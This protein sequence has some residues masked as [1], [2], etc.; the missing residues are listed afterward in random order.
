MNFY[1]LISKKTML[2]KNW[3]KYLGI[4]TVLIC[5]FI[6][7]L[8]FIVDPYNITDYNIL[9]IK[10]KFARDDRNMKVNQFK[11]LPRFDNILI[12][13]SRVYSINPDTVSKILGGTTY[14]F[15]VGTATIEDHLG[16]VK[17]LIKEDKIPKNIIIG[18][19]F[20]T[21]NPKIPP[22]S[23]F[24]RNK[25]LNFLS[26]NNYHEDKLSKLFSYNAL[27]ASLKTLKF[28]FLKK[29]KQK[30]RKNGWAGNYEDY[31]KINLN[32]EI[33]KVKSE[34][35]NDNIP[36]MY[37][38][39]QYQHIDKK[40]VAYYEELKKLSKKHHFNIY[41]F[42]TPLHPLLL[43]KLK[44]NPNTKQALTEFISYLKT[45]KHF[46]NIYT[47]SKVYDDLR[48]FHGSTHTSANAGDILMGE[49]LRK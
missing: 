33:V 48:N 36:Y 7:T 34:I 3:I 24:L 9:N 4:Y 20:Y 5:T 31:S 49:V 42:P 14:N 30:F 32:K 23:Y 6:V 46:T 40:R 12:G 41:L 29:T 18:V 17:Y 44:N 8:N 1:T 19:D 16:I 43:K 35:I 25:E 15:G 47:R 27:A 2:A 28:N 39:M 26:F 45:F 11:N 13:S 10:Y 38:D 37:S 22:N 21:F